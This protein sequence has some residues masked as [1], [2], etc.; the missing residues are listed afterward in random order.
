MHMKTILCCLLKYK[1][2]HSV[3]VADDNIPNPF[4]DVWE[5]H[6]IICAH[7]MADLCHKEEQIVLVRALCGHGYC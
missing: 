3:S 5:L 7:L 4:V 2:N 6:G 1:Q